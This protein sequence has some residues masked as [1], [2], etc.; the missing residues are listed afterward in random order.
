MNRQAF[1]FLVTFVTSLL[2]L[3]GICFFLLFK[4]LPS[5]I[6]SSVAILQTLAFACTLSPLGVII[7]SAY[8]F[9]GATEVAPSQFFSASRP[10][11]FLL[12]LF[13]LLSTLLSWFGGDYFENLRQE[14]QVLESKFEYD[15]KVEEAKDLIS[16]RSEYASNPQKAG[17]VLEK[18]QQLEVVYPFDLE[19]LRFIN[20]INKEQIEKEGDSDQGKRISRSALE[21]R[22]IEFL[23]KKDYLAASKVYDKILKQ[24]PKDRVYD[25]E[26]RAVEVA[27]ETAISNDRHRMTRFTQE[28]IS[29]QKLRSELM[30]IDLELNDAHYYQ[31][32]SQIKN[33][34]ALYPRDQEIQ[35]RW[36]RVEKSMRMDEF[37]IQ[38]FI[39]LQKNWPEPLVVH[40]TSFHL[41]NYSLKAKE[42]WL[43]PHYLYA[44]DLK[45]TTGDQSIE[46]KF[47]RIES[48]RLVVK[49][50]EFEKSLIINV[51]QLERL[52]S[53][54]HYQLP[55]YRSGLY[56]LGPLG[57][58]AYAHFVEENLH[59]DT[60]FYQL[61]ENIKWSIPIFLIALGLL[62][63]SF[64][65]EHRQHGMGL[66][67]FLYFIL[68]TAITVL[69]FF[70]SAYLLTTLAKAQH[71]DNLFK[72]MTS[73]LN[74]CFLIFAIFKYSRTH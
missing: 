24:L 26:R 25:F 58:S 55:E 72:M 39:S 54:L 65:F 40:D 50:V 44:K 53:F 6:S 30:L 8:A 61:L 70:F 48:N 4:N 46:A 3:V 16:L 14:R 51:P 38:D 17:D 5:G 68:F 11:V 69:L 52:E 12:V 28:D 35:E 60:F 31:V 74:A 63:I 29:S 33:L 64:S 59:Q 9:I 2:I 37:S 27:R 7:A 10:L 56:Y 42:L 13:V 18:L 22:A 20:K 45:L 66:N 49:D 34:A 43:A 57:L 47:G 71:Q 36:A 62:W 23:N 1:Q 21:P 15:K 32:F 73:G 41:P 19:I 67:Y